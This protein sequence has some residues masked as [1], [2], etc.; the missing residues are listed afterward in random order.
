M[1]SLT[2]VNRGARRTAGRPTRSLPGADEVEVLDL[3]SSI[4]F[5]QTKSTM[6]VNP[7]GSSRSQPTLPRRI[8]G[9]LKSG[10]ITSI[11]SANVPAV[12]P[13]TVVGW[14]RSADERNPVVRR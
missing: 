6:P 12:A 1:T 4:V 7:P 9:Y 8:D 11:S 10:S 2:V 5:E 3:M 14:L 13:V